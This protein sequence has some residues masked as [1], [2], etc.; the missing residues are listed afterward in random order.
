MVR[1]YGRVTPSEL[2]ALVNSGKVKEVVNG[3]GTYTY[4]NA[5]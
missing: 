3:N 2:E 4:R 5:N 1:G